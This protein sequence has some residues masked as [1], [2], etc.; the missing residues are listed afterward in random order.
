M[1]AVTVIAEAGVNHN[2]DLEMAR[3]LVDAAATAGADIVKFQ[4]FKATSLVTRQAPTAVYQEKFTGPDSTQFEML[5]KLELSDDHH[6]ALITHCRSRGIEF[7]STPFDHDSLRRLAREFGVKR[8]KIGSGDMT[9]Y[10]LVL[11]A[12]QTG[13][14]VIISSGMATMAEIALALG[15]LAYGYIDGASP[16]PEAF[17]AA[18]KEPEAHALLKQKAVLLHCTTEYPAP[19]GDINLRA[20]ATLR[21]RFDIP[22]GFSDHSEGNAASIA[23]AA[24]GASVIEKHITLD[25]DL[26]GPDHRASIEPDALTDLVNSI[27]TVTSALGE[28][29]KQPA[30]S[31][32]KNKVVARKSLYAGSRIPEGETFTDL[33]LTVKRPESGMSPEHYWRLLGRTASRDYEIDDAINE[34]LP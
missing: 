3:A 4:T 1:S 23:A 13:L 33:N 22:V 32:Q 29:T 26:P 25:R 27:R 21:D 28:A 11:A 30:T 34:D 14:P 8:L 5:K 19:I 24:L 20:M 18:L 15:A 6:R 16:G 10:P 2:G 31:E 17:R 9:N 7:L 12:A